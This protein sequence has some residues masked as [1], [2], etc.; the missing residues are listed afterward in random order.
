MHAQQAFYQA[1]LST[2]TRAVLQQGADSNERQLSQV[3][4]ELL[5]NTARMVLT[6]A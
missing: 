5:G 2:Y 6:I 1:C 4:A 3:G